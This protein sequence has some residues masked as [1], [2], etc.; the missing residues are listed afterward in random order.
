MTERALQGTRGHTGTIGVCAQQPWFTFR[1]APVQPCGTQRARLSSAGRHPRSWAVVGLSGKL[2]LRASLPVLLSPLCQWNYQN[3]GWS[4]ISV[5]HDSELFKE[6][7]Q[8]FGVC[9]VS[10]PRVPESSADGCQASP[11][12]PTAL[13]HNPL[14]FF[15]T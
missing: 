10:A 1:S 14:L 15:K 4:L 7:N 5:L 13:R 9:T 8:D 6:R 11:A 12:C 2:L 3:A